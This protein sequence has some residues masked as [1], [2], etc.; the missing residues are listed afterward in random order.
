MAGG[1]MRQDYRG[2]FSWQ[3][4]S[5]CVLTAERTNS[6]TSFKPGVSQALKLKMEKKN[7]FPP[8]SSAPFFLLSH[9]SPNAA[10]FPH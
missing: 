1:A 5:V 2:C 4:G 8:R 9:S 10:H 3:A 7:Q 6:P